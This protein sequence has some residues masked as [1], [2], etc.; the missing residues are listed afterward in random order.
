MAPASLMLYASV[1]VAPGG[2]KVVKAPEGLRRKP[3]YVLE[4][5]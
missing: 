4:P 5:L 2:S 3:S 1:R